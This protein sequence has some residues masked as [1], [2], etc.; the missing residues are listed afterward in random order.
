MVG[1][2]RHGQAQS[3]GIERGLAGGGGE[4]LRGGGSGIA[5]RLA[6]D[7]HQFRRLVQIVARIAVAELHACVDQL[8]QRQRGV[9]RVGRGL[10]RAP[11]A[12]GWFVFTIASCA[13]INVS[14]AAV[15]HA[16]G[17]RNGVPIFAPDSQTYFVGTSPASLTVSDINADGIPD[18]LVPNRGG[19]DVSVILGFYADDGA[20]RGREGPRLA[21]GG[22]GPIAVAVRQLTGNT[23][24]DLAVTNADSGTVTMLPGVGQ[25]F[26][27]DRQ[28]ETIFNLGGAV[29]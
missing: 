18:M 8:Q 13:V 11:V 17:I 23:I 27:D 4:R 21:S 14:N 9:S 3:G 16:I 10:R 15:Y 24:V 2:G 1:Q 5:T 28:P 12:V 19:N 25:G 7:L 22:S 20:W 29:D 6:A 26:F